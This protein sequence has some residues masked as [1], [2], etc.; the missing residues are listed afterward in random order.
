MSSSNF[1]K[2]AHNMWQHLILNDNDQ[3]HSELKKIHMYMYV[4]IQ[5]PNLRVT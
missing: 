4:K 1:L 5:M 2:K 3:Y